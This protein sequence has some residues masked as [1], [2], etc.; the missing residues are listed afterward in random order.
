MVDGQPP[1]THRSDMWATGVL[2]LEMYAGGLAALPAG[3]GENAGDLLETL[4]ETSSRRVFCQAD[5]GVRQEGC[6]TTSNR[7]G[8]GHKGINV[9]ADAGGR[10]RAGGE[11]GGVVDV[12][13]RRRRNT[14]R[15]DMPEEVVIL[16]RE[17]F[18]REAEDRPV[19]MEVNDLI[20]FLI[21]TRLCCS[22][23]RIDNEK[24]E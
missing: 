21:S 2:I 22:K 3:Q 10:L 5:G 18:E 13:G 9:G 19:S 17:M 16:L 24:N 7:G 4:V 14:L 12:G 8:G 1:Y 23:R 11:V 20:L 15:V 6:C